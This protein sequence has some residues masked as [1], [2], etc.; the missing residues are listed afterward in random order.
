MARKVPASSYENQL[1]SKGEI[2][3]VETEIAAGA[4]RGVLL[5]KS[6]HNIGRSVCD[7]LRGL[8]NPEI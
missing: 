6:A 8:T 7:R 1:L 4:A 3:V 2:V 5:Q